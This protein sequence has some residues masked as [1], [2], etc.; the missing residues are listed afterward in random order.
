MKKF[1]KVLVLVIAC[2][3]TLT[4]AACAPSDSDKAK[5]KMEKAGYTA[6]VVTLPEVGANGEV[7]TI[8]CTKS[9]EGGII[10]QISGLLTNA[11]SG[12]LYDSAKDAKA[13]FNKLKD[14][15]GN[16]AAKLIGKWVVLGDEAAVKAF[17]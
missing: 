4:F 3:L 9:G 13:A 12:T 8:T 14:A 15:E 16:T 10:G 11:F 1:F 5:A 7:A 6:I 17:K 2:A